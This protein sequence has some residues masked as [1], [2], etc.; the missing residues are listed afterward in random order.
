MRIAWAL[1]GIFALLVSGC[2]R[3]D[4]GVR[5]SWPAGVAVHVDSGN[6]SYRA[7]DY[8]EARRHFTE[9]TR[10]GPDVAA[11]W[12]GLQMAQHALGN[13]PAADSAMAHAEGL[14]GAKANHPRR[15]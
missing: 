12:F 11:A 5:A 1:C 4:A 14:L 2:E 10:R 15:L 6:A 7:R 13:K 3:T 8:A 9:A